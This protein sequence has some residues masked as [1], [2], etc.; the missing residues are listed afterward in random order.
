M[1]KA[2]LKKLTSLNAPIKITPTETYKR[3]YYHLVDTVSSASEFTTKSLN[4]KLHAAR[5]DPYE[6]DED[7]AIPA[8]WPA[9]DN[10]LD[11]SLKDPVKIA[12]SIFDSMKKKDSSFT[13]DDFEATG[14]LIKLK[15]IR[16]SLLDYGNSYEQ[17]FLSQMCYAASFSESSSYLHS[18]IQAPSKSD[19]QHLLYLS[20]LSLEDNLSDGASAVASAKTSIASKR[21]LDLFSF[22]SSVSGTLTKDRLEL[23]P[24]FFKEGSRFV[25]LAR[26]ENGNINY[27][28]IPKETKQK[29]TSYYRIG[30]L[31]K[32]EGK[33][34][35]ISSQD[36][37]SILPSTIPVYLEKDLPCSI[38]LHQDS[39][40]KFKALLQGQQLEG[41]TALSHVSLSDVN[42]LRRFETNPK[43]APLW[44]YFVDNKAY[45]PSLE[46]K[47]QPMILPKNFK[48]SGVLVGDK[49]YLSYGALSPTSMQEQRVAVYVAGFY[50]PGVLSVGNRC[51]L[52]NK[53]IVHSIALANESFSFDPSLNAG[54]QVWFE[55]ISETKKIAQELETRFKENGISQYFNI[56]PFYEYDFAKDL[57]QQFQSD[58]HLFTLIGIVIL[59]VAC[60]NIVS[61]LILMINDK[62][63]EIAI[64]QS[65]G[66]SQKSITFIFSLCGA[67]LGLLGSCIGCVAAYFTLQNI[68][69]VV[70]FLS[71][72]QG[73]ALFHEAFYGTCLPTSISS[74]ALLFLLIT[75]PLLSLLAGLVPALKTTKMNPADILRS[76]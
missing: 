13:A 14:V 48:D 43:K 58:K 17:S 32:K 59:V 15:L 38:E 24:S 49:G 61:F 34:V 66:A 18:L 67:I 69:E 11:G 41:L 2:W 5:S 3:S 21:A 55:N 27:V 45:L 54:I 26:Y 70:Q 37:A 42:P 6:P 25:A 33:V 64:L 53:N 31:E 8:Y 46:G 10:N 40:V 30:I 74:E 39:L 1:E 22:L 62:K 35:F 68:N 47:D 23:K 65:M 56:T 36:A 16:P 4:E 7:P 19:I 57:A 51:L 76:Q 73:Q 28:V 20:S 63:K 50:D 72:L 75:A 60:S 12:F 29:Q 52:L 44:P 71:L 9:P